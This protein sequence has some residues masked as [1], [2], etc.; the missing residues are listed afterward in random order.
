MSVLPPVIT[1]T[2]PVSFFIVLCMLFVSVWLIRFP[3]ITC[4]GKLLGADPAG[5]P[6]EFAA[7]YLIE[8]ERSDVLPGD[9]ERCFEWPYNPTF[10][11]LEAGRFVSVAICTMVQGGHLGQS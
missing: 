3:K 10:S 11:F 7:R 8:H 1:A 4:A 5:L 6:D 9:R 2:L